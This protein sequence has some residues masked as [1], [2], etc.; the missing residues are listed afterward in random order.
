MAVLAVVDFQHKLTFYSRQQ[1][2]KDPKLQQYCFGN[3]NCRRITLLRSVGSLEDVSGNDACCDVCTPSVPLLLLDSLV[4]QKRK[5]RHLVRRVGKVTTEQLRLRLVAER[6]KL[7]SEH[8]GYRMIGDF[9]CSDATIGEL[10]QQAKYCNNIDDVDTY[11]IRPEFRDRIFN[12][13]ME[14]VSTE[15]PPKRSRCYV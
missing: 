9:V 1:K 2:F 4:T 13:L 3:E 11:H 12:V 6:E 5:R 8:P 10:C 7:M 14:T 15:L